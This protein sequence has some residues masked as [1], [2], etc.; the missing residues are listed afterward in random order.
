MSNIEVTINAYTLPDYVDVV[1][2]TIQTA[3]GDIESEWL[4]SSLNPYE[5]DDIQ[6]QYKKI[7]L[8]L[9]LHCK[10]PDDLEQLK[11]RLRKEFTK[12]TIKFSDMSCSYTGIAESLDFSQDVSIPGMYE[13]ELSIVFQA[14]AEGEK[15]SESLSNATSK[16]LQVQGDS[17]TPCVV[18]ITPTV[19]LASLT[20]TGLAE[21]IITIKNLSSGKK[22][23]LD[24]EKC[25]VTQEGNN[26]FQ[27]C[28]FWQF[29]RL[30]PGNNTITI[31]QSSCSITITYKP[32]YL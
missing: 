28:D 13:G 4:K 26:K 11:S 7:S 29:P 32:R 17:D 25:L 19:G 23:I 14:I 21:E 3:D 18:E 8:V 12:G 9:D 31:N 27:D 20:I 2:R 1:E 10:G 30:K 6:Y 15:V 24:G 5:S 22:V 16:T